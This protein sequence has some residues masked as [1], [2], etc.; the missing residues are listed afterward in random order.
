M[1]LISKLTI[2]IPVVILAT[3]VVMRTSQVFNKTQTINPSNLS[4]PLL[5]QTS[6]TPTIIVTESD[7]PSRVDFKKDKFNLDGP[8]FCMFKDE[9]F[10]LRLYV[11]NRKISVKNTVQDITKHALVI[12][13]CLYQWSDEIDIGR[14]SCGI[15]YYI[16]IYEKML[17]LPFVSFDNIISIFTNMMPSTK[18][19][20]KNKYDLIN[21]CEIKEIEDEVFAL[22][23]DIQFE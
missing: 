17:S 14:K 5:K 23:K 19:S 9:Y 4:S 12:D 10:D 15:G 21:S 22:P 6:V 13:N 3:S 7:K 11:K 2:L 16:S 18:L 8:L 1:K 20:E